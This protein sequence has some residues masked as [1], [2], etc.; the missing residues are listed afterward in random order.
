MATMDQY[1]HVISAYSHSAMAMQVRT[2]VAVAGAEA[3]LLRQRG[4]LR[5]RLC[6]VRTMVENSGRSL[7]SRA[8]HLSIVSCTKE[9]TAGY[10]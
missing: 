2:S 3:R 10:T 8:Q 5:E 6:R 9:Q 1:H 4:N 7:G